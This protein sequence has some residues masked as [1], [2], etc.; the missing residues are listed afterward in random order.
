M[1]KAL[2]SCAKKFRHASLRLTQAAEAAR[3]ACSNASGAALVGS[4]IIC[5]PLEHRTLMSNSVSLS[6]GVLTIQGSS[7]AGSSLTASLINGG[8]SIHA[9]ADQGHATTVSLSSVKQIKIT[10]GSGSDYIYVDSAIKLPVT[11]TGGDGNDEVRGGGG[12][13]TITEGN[14]ADWIN[15][16]GTG[17]S[18]HVGNGKSVVLGSA[19][20]DTIVA[21]NGN[22][23]LDGSDGN[24]SITAGNGQDTVTADGGND[25]VV[26]GNGNDSV[27]GGLGNDKLTL[28]TGVSTVIPGSGTNYIVLGNTK[29]TVVSSSGQN[30]VVTSTGKPVTTPTG[31]VS[32]PTPPT[33]STG[34]GSTGTG[35]STGTPTWTTYS[36]SAQ[37][38]GLKAVMQVLAPTAV[39]G[40]AV[41]VRAINSTLGAGSMID[42][43]YSW[44]FGDPNGEYNTLPGFNASHVYTQAGRY[45]ITLTLTNSARQVSTVSAAITI[46]ADN[47]HAI[48][49]DAAHGSDNNDGSSPSK[50]IKTAAHASALI[51][52]NTE[53]FFARGQT[54]DTAQSF[55]VHNRNLL[56]GAY[57]SGSQPV[58]NYT[59]TG[60]GTNIVS[61]NSSHSI[62]VTI[63]DLTFTTMNGS[64]PSI[65]NQPMG[66]M[67]GGYDIAVLRCTFKDVA[68]DING[69]GAPIGLTVID[70]SSPNSNGLQGYFVWNEGTDTTLLGNYANGSVHEH[71][72]RTSSATDILA[73]DNNFVNRNSKG[74]IE[75]HNG[76]NA[77]IES[78]TVTGG[79]I[80]VGPLG[81]WNEPISSATDN[82]VIADNSVYDTY[83]RVQPGSHHVSIRNNVVHRDSA[84]M[85]DV[86]GT[87]GLGRVS[88]DIR[89]LNNTGISNGVSGNLVKVENHT[90]GI[91]M[92]NN[93]LVQP[94]LAVGANNGAPVYVVEGNLSSFTYINGN[95]WQMPKTFYSTANGGVNLVG[96]PAGTLGSLTPAAWNAQSVVGTDYFAKT[97]LSS[98]FAPSS[99]N[100]AAKAASPVVGVIAD[101]YDNSRPL[102]GSWT[103]GAVQL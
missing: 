37:S 38:S 103:A 57:G 24:D 20:N 85:I 72:V 78:N 67:A 60:T 39:V 52:D 63:Q 55:L 68:Y 98:K 88:S 17:G 8:K 94:N 90:N 44:N 25:T 18:V 2:S 101:L 42:A 87:D 97:T 40:A 82:C 43:S 102:T 69:S 66:V 7:T 29:S 56:I 48:Y 96:G 92:L 73:Y 50:A 100:V 5:E 31:T 19:G 23:S 45:T 91:T 99:G 71:I 26:V 22:D 36:A 81:L 11:I 83:I 30:T 89:I 84:M 1:F 15:L 54:F 77:W 80:R 33:G 93:L 74:C 65:A 21:G 70:S 34:S 58:I 27:N 46:A 95:V 76:A 86:S 16:G 13:N 53:V 3:L 41:D 49:V 12:A 79:D 28:G 75:I 6:N 64:N 14:G 59:R 4:D 61:A 35:S 9:S 32:N 62:G 51:K 47:R 10:G